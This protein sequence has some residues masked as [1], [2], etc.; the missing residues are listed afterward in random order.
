VSVAVS[1]AAILCIQLYS[2]LSQR[3]LYSPLYVVWLG[4]AV[5]QGEFALIKITVSEHLY[6]ECKQQIRLCRLRDSFQLLEVLFS[7]A[8]HCT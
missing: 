6:D 3:R 4:L 7:F 5:G 1:I 8:A 2:Y